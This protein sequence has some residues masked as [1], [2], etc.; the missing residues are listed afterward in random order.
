METDIVIPLA[1]GSIPVIIVAPV[2]GASIGMTPE[3][4]VGTAPPTV[5]VTGVSE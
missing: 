5:T 2:F 1:A 3:V 4:A